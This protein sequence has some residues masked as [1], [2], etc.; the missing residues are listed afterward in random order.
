ASDER[1]CGMKK[2]ATW[3]ILA[4][5]ML[6][7]GQAF[8]G[9]INE[10]VL[11]GS[12]GAPIKFTGTGG[13]QFDVTLNIQNLLAQGFGTLSS[14]GF[15]SIVNNGATVFSNGSCGTGCFMLGQSGPISFKYGSTAGSGDLLTGNLYL[16]NIVQTAQGGGIFNDQLVI[17][18]VV[19]GG[20]L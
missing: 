19:T 10:I 16:T 17:N 4:L 15:Y 20:D 11:G 18:L 9:S 8:A 5:V 13:G 12:T 2:T 14:S 7:A 3:L 6:C 1:T